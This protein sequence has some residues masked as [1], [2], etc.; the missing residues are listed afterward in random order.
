MTTNLTPKIKSL[1]LKLIISINVI[2]KYNKNI[3]NNDFTLYDK[4][5]QNQ[6]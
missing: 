1:E 5:I 6:F 4:V 2:C 3:I